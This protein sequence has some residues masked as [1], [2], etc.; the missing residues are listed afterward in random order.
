MPRH[1]HDFCFV[2]HNVS[3]HLMACVLELSAL[4]FV[5]PDE[6]KVRAQ[7]AKGPN[8]EAPLSAGYAWQPA[9][10]RCR[11]QVSRENPRCKICTPKLEYRLFVCASGFLKESF[12]CKSLQFSEF[13]EKPL[14]FAYSEI[15][16]YK[17]FFLIHAIFYTC[18]I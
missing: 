5:L 4:F 6:D 18:C 13:E 12:L 1:A 16:H 9:H 7:A 11:I 17:C 15:W 8:S 2:N 3:A 10:S 14:Q